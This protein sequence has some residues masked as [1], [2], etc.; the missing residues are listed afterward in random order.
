MHTSREEHRLR[1]FVEKTRGK[2]FRP[3]RDEVVV[4][5]EDYITRSFM[6]CTI[7]Q[8]IWYLFKE[9]KM[10]RECGRYGRQKRCI[11]GFSG[12]I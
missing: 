11:Q 2:I 10:G 3:A 6:T 5:G 12:E 7:H 4:T 9:N 1:V 8:I